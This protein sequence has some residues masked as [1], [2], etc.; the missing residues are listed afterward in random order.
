[1]KKFEYDKR[2]SVK[3]CY[4]KKQ[5]NFICNHKTVSYKVFYDTDLSEKDTCFII[6]L[7]SFDSGY[8]Y[9]YLS[10]CLTLDH[11]FICYR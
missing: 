10:L 8:N 11:C 4:F 9:S 2:I 3:K 7:V 5:L 6:S 1:M